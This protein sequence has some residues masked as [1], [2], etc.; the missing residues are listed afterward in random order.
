MSI[1]PSEIPRIAD[2]VT[3][4][5]IGG[6]V[7]LMHLVSLQTFALNETAS[8]IWSCIDGGRTVGDI[9]DAVAEEYEVSRDECGGKVME[10]I[11]SLV[12]QGLLSPA[13]RND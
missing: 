8:F 3:S 4:R 9:I 13:S 7:F 10:L 1:S 12:A 6:E 11:E 2:R 5:T